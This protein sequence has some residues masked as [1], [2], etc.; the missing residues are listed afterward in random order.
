MD[1]R[2]LNVSLLEGMGEQETEIAFVALDPMQRESERK[3]KKL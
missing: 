1:E 2:M 3:M